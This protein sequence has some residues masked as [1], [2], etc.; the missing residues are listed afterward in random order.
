L[1]H[2]DPT[3]FEPLN[4]EG[5]LSARL[6]GKGGGGAVTLVG[7]VD[8]LDRLDTRLGSASHVASLTAAAKPSDGLVIVDYKTGKA[9][10]LKYSPAMNDKIKKANFFQLRCYA[11]LLARGGP[12]KG[13][14]AQR[15][16]PLARTLR[17]LYLAD[18]G[19]GKADREG[20]TAV[21]E[22]LP[23]LGSPEYAS[24][25]EGVEADIL[26]VWQRI[27]ALVQAGD[28]HAFEHCDRPFCQC[29]DVRPLVFPELAETGRVDDVKLY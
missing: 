13:F 5:W 1:R 8:R 10:H 18:G 25:L 27:R 20:A 6:E 7:K 11:L 28:P 2:E 4:T 26:D 9:P 14:D 29:H 12:P 22:E 3:A 17:L 19:E 15:A 23:P 16:A 24:L 21:E